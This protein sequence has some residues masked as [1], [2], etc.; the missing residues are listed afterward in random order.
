MAFADDNAR[1]LKKLQKDYG[2]NLVHVPFFLRFAFK[3]NFNKE[4]DKSDYAERKVFLIAYETDL[5]ASQARD[6]EEAKEEAQAKK[7]AWLAK[8]AQAQKERDRLKAEQDEA[9]QEKADEIAQQKEFNDNLRDQKQKLQDMLR[10]AQ[11]GN[12]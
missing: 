4:W 7:D 11:Q 10:A 12:T 6:K 9:K 2:N 3:R 5:E 8:K 1:M